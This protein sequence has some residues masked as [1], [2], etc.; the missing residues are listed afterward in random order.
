MSGSR[1]SLPRRLSRALPWWLGGAAF[2]SLAAVAAVAWQ[3]A[4]RQRRD[5]E[6]ALRQAAGDAATRILPGL[7]QGLLESAGR[8]PAARL[9]WFTTPGAPEDWVFGPWPQPENAQSTAFTAAVALQREGKTEEARA[10][11]AGAGLDSPD[12]LLAPRASGETRPLATTTSGLPL[13]PLVLRH[14]LQTA[15]DRT[16]RSRYAAALL[17]AA[18]SQPSVLT[19]A[20]IDEAAPFVEDPD[21]LETARADALHLDQLRELLRRHRESVL[22]KK[23][24]IDGSWHLAY[25]AGEVT[26]RSRGELTSMARIGGLPVPGLPE[27]WSFSLRLDGVSLQKP[28]PLPARLMAARESGAWR[29][30]V[31]TRWPGAAFA[32][33]DQQL[34]RQRWLIAGATGFMSAALGG[35]V[36]VLARQRRLNA[37]MSNFVASV[38]HE[39]RAPVASLGLLAERLGDGRIA[40]AEEQARYHKLIRG[41]SRRLSATIENVLTF[42]RRERGRLAREQDLC[43]LTALLRDALDIVRPLAEERR[44]TLDGALPEESVERELD[45]AAIRQAVLNLLDNALKFSPPGGTIHL[46]LRG[47]NGTATITVRDEGPGV[48]PGERLRIFE[49]FYRIGSELRRETPGIGIGLAIVREAALAHHGTVLVRDAPGGGAEF[50]FTLRDPAAL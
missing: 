29:V 4:D 28:E 25:T 16:A 45:P 20:L 26:A 12:A 5:G 11:L 38:S 19:R 21:T 37:M 6:G 50:I 1:L 41:E 44:V 27:G 35:F 22:T 13:A 43:D 49:P 15:P 32:T 40:G 48:P 30:E 31:V 8:T 3:A 24:W 36:W 14:L 42:S 2:L 10:A 46:S 9:S 23:P 47:E 33:L 7:A 34:A 18:I 39:L 17:Q